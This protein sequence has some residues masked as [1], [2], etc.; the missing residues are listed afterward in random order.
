MTEPPHTKTTN[1]H[2]H[3]SEFSEKIVAK[4][5][6]RNQKTDILRGQHKLRYRTRLWQCQNLPSS[7][8]LVVLFGTRSPIRIKTR[9]K[10][11]KPKK[12]NISTATPN[13]L[14]PESFH[15]NTTNTPETGLFDSFCLFSPTSEFPQPLEIK[16][17]PGFRSR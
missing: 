12:N 14:Q 1:H 15:H 4:K 11:P 6:C 8:H 17:F 13:I 5:R 9:V 16:K 7:R 10:V 3:C 2:D